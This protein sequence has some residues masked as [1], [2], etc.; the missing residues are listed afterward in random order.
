MTRLILKMSGEAIGDTTSEAPID[1]QRLRAFVNGVAGA[2]ST[3][4]DIELGIVVGGGNIVRGRDLPGTPAQY[5]DQMGMLGT[6][7]NGLALRAGLEAVGL[8][9]RLMSSIEMRSVAE[10]YTHDGC[11]SHLS[12]KRVV[13]LAGGLGL[14][15]FTTDTAATHRAVDVAADELL[16]AKFGTDGIYD[17]DPNVNF[18]AKKLVEVTGSEV[19]DRKLQVMDLT[20]IAFC[21]E[22]RLPVYVFDMDEEDAVQQS[23]LG[24]RKAG[25]RIVH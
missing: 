9:C 21:M 19:L 11:R 18:D 5:A 13:V 14:Q 25:S 23:L 4:P 12:K 20:A 3:N 6:V 1:D 8:E 2:L 24:D 17:S 16:L 7:I 15:Y 10:P 22:N